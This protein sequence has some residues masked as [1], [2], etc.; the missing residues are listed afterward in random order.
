MIIQIYV[1]DQGKD[2]NRAP[3]SG[4]GQL[5]M[6][7]SGPSTSRWAPAQWDSKPGVASS[8]FSL[9]M[10][11]CFSQPCLPHSN[12]A[13]VVQADATGLFPSCWQTWIQ[14]REGDSG[15]IRCKKV[16]DCS[17]WLWGQCWR[18]VPFSLWR[19]LLSLYIFLNSYIYPRLNLSRE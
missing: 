12:N 10:T 18:T 8:S 13:M 1:V 5:L 15:G 3:S 14:Q 4:S 16:A 17:M 2:K 7:L 6:L 19:V 11:Q 9:T